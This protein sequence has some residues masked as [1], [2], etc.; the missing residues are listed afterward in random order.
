MPDRDLDT[1]LAEMA[2]ARRAALHHQARRDTAVALIS[3][4]GHVTA[5]EVDAHLAEHLTLPPQAALTDAIAHKAA[6][7]ADHADAGVEHARRALQAAHAKRDKLA[8]H[9]AAA[10]TAVA[11][12]ETA[13]DEAADTARQARE[14]ADYADTGHPAPPGPPTRAA[15]APA[16]AATENGE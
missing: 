7:A 8:A 4:H 3:E 15:A 6:A 13:A 16:R 10:D 1:R 9:L 5:D 2:D 14:L 12:C 11:A